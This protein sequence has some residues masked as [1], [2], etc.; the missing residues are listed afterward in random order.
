MQISQIQ[1]ENT[2]FVEEVC[3]NVDD[4]DLQFLEVQDIL[5]SNDNNENIE[6]K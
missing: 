5:Q 6:S 1:P 3:N 2:G 4:D